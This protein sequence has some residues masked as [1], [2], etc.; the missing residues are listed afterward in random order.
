[1]EIIQD[2]FAAYPVLSVAQ[3]AFMVWMLVDAYRRQAETFWFLVI[4]F[5]PLLG[6]WVYFFAVKARDFPSLRLGALRPGG[7]FQ[8]RPSL[9]ELRYRAERM[10][11]LVSQVTLAQ[12]LIELGRYEEAI[13]HLQAALKTE[14]EHAP[15]LYS[16]AVCHKEMGNADR[17]VPLL[18]GLLSRDPR[19]SNYVGWRL[20]IEARLLA[21]DPA[22]SLDACR[23]L[24]RLAPTLEHTCLLAEHLLAGGRTEE[25]RG[26]LERSL[27]DHD[28]APGP[29]RRRNRRWASAAR[30]LR[31]RVEAASG[32]APR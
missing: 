28:Y 14:P 20:L 9:D 16:L 23:E 29:I 32:P 21:G 6:A 3:T 31:K 27:R 10:P 17:A 4:F 25:A 11:T 12:R 22:G 2:L 15:A 7:L 1:M 18:Q 19:W 30:R 5:V 13:P 24:V 26:V 8:R